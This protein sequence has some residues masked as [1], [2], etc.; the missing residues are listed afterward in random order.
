M[1][2]FNIYVA[3][4][5]R[6]ETT[7]VHTLLE[8]CTYVV[9][10]SE[11]QKYK[12]VGIES[13]WAIDDDEINSFCKVHNYIIDHAPEDIVC[14]LD[15]D[16]AH[17]RYSL[18]RNL[19]IKSKEI[20]TREIE[21]LA[22]IQYDLGVGLLGTRITASPLQYSAEYHF[23]GMIGPIRIYNRAKL[24]SRY[25]EMRFFA[26]TDFVLQEL[27]KNRIILRPDY[28][29]SDAKLETNKGGMNVRR[30]RDHQLKI[31]EEMK[32]KWGKYFSY[33]PENNVSKISVKR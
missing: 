10:K 15:D 5:H 29:A 32:E 20:A 3:S 13:T 26:D 27:L 11:E 12:D 16:M 24:K 4:A 18:D 21:R 14:V 23:S 1:A 8:Y 19:P 33:R 28:F 6:W 7:I 31:A 30:T 22:Q 17:F 2:T 25:I 9:R